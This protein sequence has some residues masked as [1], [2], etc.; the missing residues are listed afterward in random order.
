MNIRCPI[1]SYPN[2]PEAKKCRRCGEE[3][4]ELCPSCG[5]I[6]QT[7]SSF[8]SVCGQI[9][10]EGNN[11]E[12]QVDDSKKS[13][14]KTVEKAPEYVGP[15]P[16]DLMEC[17]KCAHVIAKQVT[18]CT[19]CGH[20]FA[21]HQRQIDPAAFD[22]VEQNIEYLPSS[23][24]V[25]QAEQEP[26]ESQE[27]PKKKKGKPGKPAPG[28][29]VAKGK[30]S[31]P[32]KGQP[33]KVAKGAKKPKP[34]KNVS[35]PASKVAG[36][37]KPETDEDGL[38]ILSKLRPLTKGSD[39]KKAPD[40]VPPRPVRKS[41]E[42]PADLSRPERPPGEDV[43]KAPDVQDELEK[44]AKEKQEPT[45][46]PVKRKPRPA[47][48]PEPEPEPE[49]IEVH[50]DSNTTD[51]V[52][53]DSEWEDDPEE[54]ERLRASRIAIKDIK[55]AEAK[56]KIAVDIPTYIDKEF[57]PVPPYY[58]E[59]EVSEDQVDIPNSMVF[60]PGGNFL[61]GIEKEDEKTGPFLID[62]YP[63]TCEEYFKFCEET[64][65]PKPWDWG[66][67]KYLLGMENHPVIFVNAND[68]RAFAA[69][70]GKRL[71][72]EMEWEKAAGGT[73][74]RLYP[75]GDDFIAENCL[76]KNHVVPKITAAVD[77]YKNAAGPY[78]VCDMV[79]NV[80]EWVEQEFKPDGPVLLPVLKGGSRADTSDVA[81]CRSRLFIPDPEVS[82]PYV[83]F[84]C[85]KDIEQ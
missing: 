13:K 51:T 80:S 10:E 15:R 75:W 56:I 14:R 48:K 30:K 47:P 12:H 67:G 62:T 81:T 41:A 83:G 11:H 33:G 59:K 35:I 21:G 29:K 24:E 32:K 31:P 39:D 57:A 78:G 4:P 23:K 19:Y 54:I 18:F 79:G 9:F 38:G 65:Y 63:V 82:T 85:V 44:A 52:D 3:L 1:C 45:P 74:G 50:V 20:R 6:L 40:A 58:P 5:S 42:K 28:K 60:V 2:F 70:A 61:F 37:G 34:K 27:K 77:T 7:H 46:E 25:E 84:R 66:Y 16:R 72:T 36:M 64:K 68:A 55:R 69:W 22:K 71:P 73:D 76:C 8:C 17:P 53:D 26:Q 49:P 43:F